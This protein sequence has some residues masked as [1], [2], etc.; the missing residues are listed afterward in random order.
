MFML[1]T[2]VLIA[3]FKG[4]HGVQARITAEGFDQCL[5]SEL[6]VAELYVGLYKD[7]YGDAD[8]ERIVAKQKQIDFVLE[9]FETVPFIGSSRTYGKVRAELE[10]SG[11]RLSDMDLLIGSSA[12]DAGCTLVTNN[13]RHLSRIPGLKVEDWFA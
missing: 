5:V 6:S 11:M 13:I 1:D 10:S 4:Q 3:M 8:P 9:H 12:L 7:V 2:N